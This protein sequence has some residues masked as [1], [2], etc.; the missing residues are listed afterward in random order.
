MSSASRHAGVAPGFVAPLCRGAGSPRVP[1]A[2]PQGAMRA[3]AGHDD[4]EA[5]GIRRVARMAWWD[6]PTG[7]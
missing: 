7:Y 2:G 1:R 4:V 5:G 6:L 3:R